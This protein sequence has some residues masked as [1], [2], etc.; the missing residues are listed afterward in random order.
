MKKSTRPVNRKVDTP[1]TS[2]QTGGERLSPNGTSNMDGSSGSNLGGDKRKPVTP[3]EAALTAKNY[4]LA[5]ELVRESSQT[6]T[7]L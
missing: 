2:G 7:I 5:K 1:Q 4:R 3:E 6:H